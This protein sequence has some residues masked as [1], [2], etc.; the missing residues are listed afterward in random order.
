MRVLDGE[1]GKRRRGETETGKEKRALAPHLPLIRPQSRGLV[2]CRRTPKDRCAAPALLH[3]Q[4]WPCTPETEFLTVRT[5]H[6]LEVTSQPF[7][8]RLAQQVGALG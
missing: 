1:P 4:G 8:Q 3:H 6:P 5:P 2:F 7:Q